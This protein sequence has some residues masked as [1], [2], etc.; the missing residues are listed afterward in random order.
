MRRNKTLRAD[1]QPA[2]AAP[3]AEERIASVARAICVVESRT[4]G[5]APYDPQVPSVEM[6]DWMHQPQHP[7]NLK[8]RLWTNSNPQS[9]WPK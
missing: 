4:P 6:A 8:W 3:A 2:Q 9:V 1:R 7:S 5:A